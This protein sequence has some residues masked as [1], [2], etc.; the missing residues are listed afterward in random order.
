MTL[1]R[2][3]DGRITLN[4]LNYQPWE[5]EP[6][7]VYTFEKD[8]QVG[9]HLVKSKEGLTLPPKLYGNVE[10]RSQRVLKTF[11]L[12]GRLGV[13]LYG[14]K[15]SGKSLLA[16]HIL[17]SSNL[18]IISMNK[19]F[20]PSEFGPFLD[21]V[22]PHAVFFDEF[23]KIYN[24]ADL[25]AQLLPFFDSAHAAKRLV[26]VTDNTDHAVSDANRNRPGRFHYLWRFSGLE[27]AFVRDYINDHLT[28]PAEYREAVLQ[29]AEDMRSELSFDILRA[30]VWEC[31]NYHTELSPADVLAPLNAEVKPVS[32]GW[33]VS[34]EWSEPFAAV[35]FLCNASKYAENVEEIIESAGLYSVTVLVKREHPKKPF[36]AESG[37]DEDED[38][39]EDYSNSM[40]DEEFAQTNYWDSTKFQRY[41]TSFNFPSSFLVQET[42]KK[43]QYRFPI[44]VNGRLDFALLRDLNLFSYLSASHLVKE[45]RKHQNLELSLFLERKNREVFR[46]W[47]M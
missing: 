19:P 27:E 39:D 30:L 44:V 14:L 12:L 24:D 9:L 2:Y 36:N 46:S 10:A 5:L 23:G 28:A 22:G 37:E 6:G 1:R 31:N 7:Q 20:S 41:S 35:G 38:I 15:G 8:M 29:R 21:Y 26:V 45:F 16:A 3:L 34:F 4:T 47:A 33:S 11:G 13:A 32:Y 18:P 17:K 42:A 40:T 43:L 25:Q